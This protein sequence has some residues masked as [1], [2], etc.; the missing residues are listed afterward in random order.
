MRFIFI[1]F[2]KESDSNSNA[3][4]IQSKFHCGTFLE[5]HTKSNS[6]YVYTASQLV[7]G[8][9][10]KKRHGKENIDKGKTVV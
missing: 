2:G 10:E 8:V 6:Y 4:N 3:K 9:N 7:L 5:S 1:S